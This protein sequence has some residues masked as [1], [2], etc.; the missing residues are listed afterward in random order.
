MNNLCDCPHCTA[1]WQQI[2]KR[3]RNSLSNIE[4]QIQQ[5]RMKN[6]EYEKTTKMLR[7]L[8]NERSIND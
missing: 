4:N 3:L 8:D 1:R 2:D 6:K 5:S 7:L